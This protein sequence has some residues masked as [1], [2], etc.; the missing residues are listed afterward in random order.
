MNRIDPTTLYDKQELQS[1][2]KGVVKIETL[3]SFGLVGAPGKGYWGGNVIDALNRYW[4]NLVHQRDTGKVSGKENHLEEKPEFFE[5]REQELQSGDVHI[6]ECVDQ[7]L[8]SEWER[9]HRKVS[10]ASI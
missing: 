10:K 2:L 1:L 6:G 4:D 8:E 5:N 9:F 3:R 7:P